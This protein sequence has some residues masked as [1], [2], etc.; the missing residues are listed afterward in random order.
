MVNGNSRG[1][2][3]PLHDPQYWCGTEHVR[4]AGVTPMGRGALT[5]AEALQ[6]DVML[7]DLKMPVCAKNHHRQSQDEMASILPDPAHLTSLPCLIEHLGSH[8]RPE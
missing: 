2:P 1:S 7:M 4:A 5:Q 3:D 6:P 8:R